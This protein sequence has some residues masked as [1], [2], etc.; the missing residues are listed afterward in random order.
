MDWTDDIAKAIWA[1]VAVVVAAGA[2][3][4]CYILG[5]VALAVI[6]PALETLR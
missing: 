2:I 4:L 1:G 6:Y 5:S 3:V